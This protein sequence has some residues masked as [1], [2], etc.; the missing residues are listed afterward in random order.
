MTQMV[1]DSDAP[2]VNNGRF[3]V[4]SRDSD[5]ERPPGAVSRV[6]GPACRRKGKRLRRTRG[7]PASMSQVST[8]AAVPTSL[9]EALE[10]DLTRL[11][12]EME[13]APMPPEAP[14]LSIAESESDT[15][16]VRVV[17]RDDLCCSLPRDE[18]G[19]GSGDD[20]QMSHAVGEEEPNDNLLLVPH[21]KAMSHGFRGLDEVDVV[22]V[23]EVRA[24]VMK[25]V[26]KFMKGVFRGG[27]KLS[28]QEIAKGR[29]RNDS[30][31]ETR[32][33]KLFLSLPRLLLFRPPS[34]RIGA[35]GQVART[36]VHVC[37]R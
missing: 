27:L 19:D 28:L 3:M 6:A 31:M 12:S 26:P 2:L 9:S 11:D 37:R 24:Q 30:V 32:G 14:P 36:G 16:S 34:R 1:I 10:F 4:L 18:Y 5:D 17:P 21:T 13:Q 7:D 23:F 25:T 33:W 35:Q 29:A 20:H 22:E 15:E 8:I